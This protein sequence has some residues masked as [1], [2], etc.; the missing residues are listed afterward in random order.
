M[1]CL[2]AFSLS[3]S[4]FFGLSC[5]LTGT[6]QVPCSLYQWGCLMAV[7][8]LCTVFAFCTL[9]TGVRIL[10][11]AKAS[12]INMLEPATGVVFGVILFKENCR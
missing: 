6:L 9:M 4:L 11:A 7:S 12:V 2:F 1:L 10:G 3:A 8:L 5:A